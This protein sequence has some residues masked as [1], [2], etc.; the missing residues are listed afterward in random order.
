M[1]TYDYARP[2]L[3]RPK[4]IIV[5]LRTYAQLNEFVM[6]KKK[7]NQV[8]C[9]HTRGS[10]SRNGQED[11]VRSWLTLTYAVC[12]HSD[13]VGEPVKRRSTQT[14]TARP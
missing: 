7:K 10:V 4:C 11:G 2:A 9:N 6:Q 3:L 1:P 13:S 14:I 12:E 5:D 8:P